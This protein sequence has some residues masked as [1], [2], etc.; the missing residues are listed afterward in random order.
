MRLLH[1]ADWHLGHHLH[2]HDRTFEHGCF[3][4]WL[5][6][7][8]RARQIDGLLVA[9]DLFDTAN[10]AAASWQLFYRFL[11]RLRAEVPHLNVVVIGGNH[12]S[13][14]KL[15]APHELLKAFELHLVGAISRD[16]AGA[17]DVERLI[18][19]LKDKF[20]TI[21]AWCAAV[22]YLRSADLRWDGDEGEGD[23]LVAG[24]RAIYAEVLAAIEARRTPEQAVIALGHAYLVK[25]ELSQL[26]ERKVL[27]GNQHALPLD[28]FTG[29]DLV[30][31]G[32]L[33]L[34]QSP[35]PHIHYS[36]SPLP[37]SLAEADY[38][39][40]VLEFALQGAEVSLVARHPVP[41]AVEMLRIPAEAAPLDE[42]VAE[43]TS[44]SLPARPAEQRPYLEVRVQ[45]DKP[46]ARIREKIL[47]A[48]A[49]KPVRLAR[50]TT[51]YTGHGLAMADTQ[52][53]SQLDEL[54]PEQVF[55]LCYARQH[56]SAP[57]QA[58]EQAFSELLT[59]LQEG[60]A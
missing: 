19:P 38:R 49:D 16:A 7:L 1:T 47:A 14:S 27:G 9:G 35:A 3:L 57:D 8:I 21:Q 30:A 41:R 10:P 46:E 11:A 34:A 32:H 33:H 28:L 37:L 31:L 39:H 5:S 51:H 15:D 24:V 12:D 45:L 26:S 29:A 56:A 23:R 4:D 42:V 25:G 50:I 59:Q 20:G 48:L 18:V 22:P 36:G 44:L 60:Q 55:R 17:L 52:A 58:L 54:S 2:G 6:E 13:P 43:L 53:H 40:Q